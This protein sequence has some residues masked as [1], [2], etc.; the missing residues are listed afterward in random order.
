[1]FKPKLIFA[2]FFG[3][4][5]VA[6][7]QQDKPVATTST[8]VESQTTD[9]N[10]M[11]IEI[12]SDVVCPFCYIGKRK[13]EQALRQ[14][15]HNDQISVVWKSFQLDPD[16]S[17][18]GEDYLKSL[19]ERK[20]WSLEQTSQIT[21]N[22]TNMAAEV[23]LSFHFDKAISANSLDAHRLLHLAHQDGSQDALKEALFRAHFVE[24]KN[25]ADHAVLLELGK[26]VG[27]DAAEIERTLK[28]T[29]YAEAVQQDIEEAR[30]F[31]V[32]GVPFFVFDRKYA[33]S[34]A[35]HMDVFQ[36]TLIKAFEDQ[37]KKK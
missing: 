23:G 28:S 31:R 1:M 21:E 30:K 13:L 24:G 32:S 37:K 8:Q 25:I 19:S 34:G 18:K 5:Y 36:Q 16:A 9:L 6:C 12:W 20:G 15:P 3:L 33:I 14:F 29:D 4:P 10:K 17:A 11:H 22:V 7:A 2:L 27:L 35:Q 26:S